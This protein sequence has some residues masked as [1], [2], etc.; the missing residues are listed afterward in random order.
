M[1]LSKTLYILIQK[2]FSDSLFFCFSLF[3]K[4]FLK[5]IKVLFLA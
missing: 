2:R 5:E 4:A 1:F 3:Y